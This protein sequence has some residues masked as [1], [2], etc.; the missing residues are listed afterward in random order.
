MCRVSS[1]GMNGIQNKWFPSRL[2]RPNHRM[3]ALTVRKQARGTKKIV[4]VTT[5]VLRQSAPSIVAGRSTPDYILDLISLRAEAFD[6]TFV[7]ATGGQELQC[8]DV[9]QQS[10]GLQMLPRER[11]L[12]PCRVLLARLIFLFVVIFS[13][14]HCYYF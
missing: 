3:Y 6:Y 9:C 11:R 7:R 8:I 2:L 12:L 4:C 1:V 13:T 14:V 5:N 10:T